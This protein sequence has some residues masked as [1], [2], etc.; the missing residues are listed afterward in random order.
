MITSQFRW[1]VRL[2]SFFLAIT[3]LIIVLI[4]AGFFDPS[5]IGQQVRQED[6]PKMSLDA[7]TRKINW[8]E[9]SVP[10]PPYSVRLTAAL[11]QGEEDIAY[12]LVLGNDDSYYAIA[13]SPLG[14]LA[15]WETSETETYHLNWQT[16]PHI[17]TGKQ[18]NEIWLDVVNDQARVRIN[19]EWLW[20]GVIDSAGDNIGILGESFGE[21]SV[22][23][24]D[25]LELFA[26]VDEN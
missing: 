25:S 11:E 15:I 4:T 1:I 19:R 13:V 26:E 14:Y 8:L 2:T 6:L 23:E 3:I 7:S 9:S 20:E 10:N 5:P 22:I 17:R 24:F 21:E 12:G 16:W 18:Q